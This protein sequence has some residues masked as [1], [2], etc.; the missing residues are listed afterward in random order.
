MAYY[1]L[2]AQFFVRLDGTCWA[3][4]PRPLLGREKREVWRR[5]KGR[6]ALCH[7]RLKLYRGSVFSD[8]EQGHVD[9]IIPLSRGGS[10]KPR[11]LRLICATS[12]LS[13]KAGGE[14]LRLCG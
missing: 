7:R 10:N 2:R 8:G 6:C 13:L 4:E 3:K 12:N 11:N 5:F 9:H 14:A 1:K